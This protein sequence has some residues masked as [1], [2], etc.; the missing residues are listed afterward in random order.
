MDKDNKMA[1]K[2]SIPDTLIPKMM[3][4]YK[5]TL[6]KTSSNAFAITAAHDYLKSEGSDIVRRT[7]QRTIA[8]LIGGVYK[9]EATTASFKIHESREDEIE[10]LSGSIEHV[11]NVLLDRFHDA[12]RD[13]S[14][15]AALIQLADALA[16][17]RELQAKLLSL[18]PKKTTQ[19][20]E[21][22]TNTPGRI[23]FTQQV[24]NEE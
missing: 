10:H 3:E 22:T 2:T 23:V 5:E 6:K 21:V 19:T 24:D 20:T 18:S 7:V 11:A 13:K 8:R 17:Q 9:L 16:R 4:T 12:I 14:P 1:V 15:N